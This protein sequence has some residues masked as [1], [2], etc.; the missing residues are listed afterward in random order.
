MNQDL[1][2]NVLNFN[3]PKQAITLYIALEEIGECFS[4]YKTKFP[5]DIG[6]SFPNTDFNK[7]DEIYTTFDVPAEGYKPHQVI[8]DK[9]NNRLYKQYLKFKLKKHFLAK[10]FI[11]KRNF[12]KDTQVWL[13]AINTDK[14]PYNLNYKFSLKIQF[15]KV[16]HY[17]ELV[18]SYDGSTK[19]LKKSIEEI[20]R[21]DLIKTAIHQQTVFNYNMSTEKDWEKELWNKLEWENSY[22]ILNRELANEYQIE[23]PLDKPDNKYKTYMKLVNGFTKNEIFNDD[24]RS[25]IDIRS[26][27]W[28]K[29]PEYRLDNVNPEINLLQ[30]RNGTG[31]MPQIE[32]V[33]NKC[34]ERPKK[35][36]VF[37]IFQEDHKDFVGELHTQFQ[38]GTGKFYPG[39]GKFLDT[40]FHSESKNAI[41][42]KNPNEIL[43]TLKQRL[44]E[45]VF[46]EKIT[47]AAIYISPF[48]KNDKDINNRK[49]YYKAKELL[50]KN[51]IVSQVIDY[52]KMVGNFEDYTQQF[53][54][55]NISLALLA[56]LQGIPWKLKTPDKKEL[57]IGIGAFKN[58]DE[59][60][61]YVGSAF[62]FQN[63][64]T[65][66]SFEYFKDYETIDLAG[67]ITKAIRT[68][69]AISHS[70]KVVIHFYKT[71]GYEDLQ[72]ILAAMKSLN[73]E[74]PLYILNINKT[75]SE[76]LIALDNNWYNKLMPKSG[77]FI[78]VGYN[79]YLLFNNS[80]HT[81]MQKYNDRD[82]Y[83]FPIKIEISSPTEG[84]LDDNTIIKGL[85]EQVYQFSRL[86]WKSLKQQNVPITIKYPEMVAQIAPNF[87]G[88]IPEDAKDKLWFL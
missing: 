38:K 46:D 5:E 19:I 51:N 86:Y 47:Y 62:S 78:R 40:P 34:F 76:D 50:L 10:G 66:N 64:G 30:Y 68:F 24:F 56:K 43:T 2:F 88:N 27:N 29:V 65:F 17:P 61:N 15:N 41:I 26:K 70:D 9:F 58:T 83:P 18:I 63:N 14:I 1:Y 6:K 87:D 16:S 22:P 80:R 8:F 42:F 54:L 60:I 82:G 3:Y 48:S 53:T 37:Y 23:I 39:M 35:Y 36:Q 31:R 75:D 71:M 85:I 33:R 59:D 55:S 20:T 52:E 73:L 7:L 77:T 12:V 44:E 45:I 69:Y 72:P 21:T 25:I 67:S 74:V 11:C 49:I 32:M 79:Q 4:I 84:A 81:N 13:P 57:I 28:V